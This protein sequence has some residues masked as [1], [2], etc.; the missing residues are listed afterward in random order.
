MSDPAFR[1]A[2]ETY[3]AARYASSLTSERIWSTA[4]MRQGRLAE[5]R[6]V[7]ADIAKRRPAVPDDEMKRVAAVL[8]PEIQRLERHYASQASSIAGAAG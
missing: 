7:A 1:D 8:A 5:L 4:V 3:V 2:V 6:Q